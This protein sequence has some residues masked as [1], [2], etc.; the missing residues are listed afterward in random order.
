MRN[1]LIEQLEN[2]VTEEQFIKIFVSMAAS[3]GSIRE[4]KRVRKRFGIHPLTKKEKRV[5]SKKESEG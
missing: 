3:I 2:T 1:L 5:L 4:I